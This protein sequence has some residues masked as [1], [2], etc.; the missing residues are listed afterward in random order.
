MAPN[1]ILPIGSSLAKVLV[2]TKQNTNR[3]PSEASH[4]PKL[5][6]GPRRPTP[7]PSNPNTVKQNFTALVLAQL[8]TE[9]KIR[10]DDPITQYVPSLRIA[11][12]RRPVF[13][14]IS[15]SIMVHD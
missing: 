15:Y 6:F 2:K 11:Q 1:I 3:L 5:T 12:V 10:L 7:T 8:H 4:H 9:G 13:V 14:S